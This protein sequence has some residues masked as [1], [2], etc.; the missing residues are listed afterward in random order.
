MEEFTR[1]PKETKRGRARPI[2]LV[3]FDSFHFKPLDAANGLRE[4]NIDM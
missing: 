1:C 4:A 2:F 3:Y